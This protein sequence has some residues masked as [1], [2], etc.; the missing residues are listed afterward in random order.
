MKNQILIILC[1]LFTISSSAQTGNSIKTSQKGS[2]STQVNK[3]NNAPVSGNSII[4]QIV[5][6]KTCKLKVTIMKCAGVDMSNPKM[7]QPEGASITRYAKLNGVNTL[8]SNENFESVVV[9]FDFLDSPSKD[10]TSFEIRDNNGQVVDFSRF[11]GYR[12]IHLDIPKVN[13]KKEYFAV[14]MGKN[15]E[16]N[17]VKF[18][19]DNL[20]SDPRKFPN[21][22]E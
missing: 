18:V 20:I 12:Q 10:V 16:Y 22:V 7:G 2:N 6:N 11:E 17:S 3:S 19:V 5:I 1:A 8:V 21:F 13:C 14:F 4:D 9:L 15:G